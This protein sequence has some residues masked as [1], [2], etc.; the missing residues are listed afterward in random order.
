M[1]SDLKR[2]QTEGNHH[3]VTFSCYQRRPYLNND[4]A[5]AT[6][7]EVLE[8]VRRRHQFL[9]FGYVLMPEHVHLLMSEPKQQ[10]LADT[11]RVLK[12]ESSKRLKGRPRPFWQTRYHDFNV[13]TAGKQVEKLRY[14]HR[15]PVERGLVENPEDW[16]WSSFRHYLTGETGRVEI[17]SHWTFARRQR[18]SASHSSQ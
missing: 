17:E 9:V 2:F 5:R 11:L 4:E 7:E 15:N 14:L 6:F 10:A 16:P 1:P 8:A 13:I 18:A 3:F 12:G